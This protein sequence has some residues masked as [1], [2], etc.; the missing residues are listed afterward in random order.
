MKARW[1]LNSFL[2]PLYL[3][4]QIF[5]KLCGAIQE[6]SLEGFDQGG[7]HDDENDDGTAEM[8]WVITRYVL[9]NIMYFT[10]L[11]RFK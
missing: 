2:R 1:D 11:L 4:L 10:G 7:R 8:Y 5:C 3:I 9:G 6:E